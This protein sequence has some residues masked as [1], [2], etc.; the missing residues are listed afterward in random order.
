MKNNNL[1][2]KYKKSNK[3]YYIYHKFEIRGDLTRN[4]FHRQRRTAI[5]YKNLL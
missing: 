4:Y 2:I 5:I 1:S 3:L